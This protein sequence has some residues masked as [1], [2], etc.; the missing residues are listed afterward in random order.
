MGEQTAR[1]A[2]EGVEGEGKGRVR[3]PLH[4]P[5]RH[6]DQRGDK[7]RAQ[8]TPEQHTHRA[9]RRGSKRTKIGTDAAAPPRG[10]SAGR[11]GEDEDGDEEETECVYERR[12]GLAVDEHVEPED[13]EEDRFLRPQS[14]V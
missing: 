8:Y 9:R 2:R 4:R 12:R 1:E 14:A 5:P 11:G 6:R 10:A 3:V 7:D 13:V